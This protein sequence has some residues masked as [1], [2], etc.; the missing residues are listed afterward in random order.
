MSQKFIVFGSM[1]FNTRYILSCIRPENNTV[2]VRVIEG[3][4]AKGYTQRFTSEN[5]VDLF[6]ASLHEPTTKQEHK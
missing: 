1:V 4:S 6:F 5:E 3:L 2:T